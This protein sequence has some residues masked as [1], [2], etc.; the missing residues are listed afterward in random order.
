MLVV[1]VVVHMATIQ[2]KLVALVALAVVVKV[3][4]VYRI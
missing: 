4:T 2:I 1:A 3:V